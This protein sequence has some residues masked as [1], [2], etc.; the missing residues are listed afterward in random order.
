MANGPQRLVLINAGRYDYAEIELRG[1]LQIV[2]P[3][4]TGKTTLINTLQFLY[5]DDRRHMEFG[6]YTLEQTW[7]YYFPNQYSYILFEALTARGICVIGWRG[8]TRVIGPE[9]ERFIFDG[10][11]D[12][13]DFVDGDHQVREPKEINSR[14]SLKNYRVLKNAQEHRELLLLTTKGESRGLGLV[15]LRDNDRYGHFRETLK[16]L[17]CLST[18]S[19]DQMR[20]Q[21]LML[22]GF[23]ADRQALNI[24]EAFGEDYD[25]ILAQ[26]Q[27]LVRFKRQEKEIEL[28][29]QASARRTMLRGE[30]VSRWR[31]LR[32]KRQLFE[33]DHNK[34]VKELVNAT[35]TAAADVKEKLDVAGCEA[36]SAPRQA[37][38]DIIKADVAV[39]AK[40]VKEAGITAD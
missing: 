1:S 2:G 29:L 40:V 11:F 14:L 6:S 37:F 20:A 36:K 26:K 38:A 13:E 24:R 25:R 34:K 15:V 32:F 10:P 35:E 3:N 30:L 9:P 33:Q 23:S 17:L 7:D 18:I 28:L 31:N 22:T 4:N 19:Q 21:V 39:W 27:K 5:L 12:H 8:Q 16:S